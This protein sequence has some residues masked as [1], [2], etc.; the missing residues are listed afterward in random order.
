[1]TEQL[2]LQRLTA[3]IMPYGLDDTTVMVPSNEQV[4]S[5]PLHNVL[6]TAQFH[7]KELS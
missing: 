2:I 3:H 7:W 1:M 5:I 6:N 4:A